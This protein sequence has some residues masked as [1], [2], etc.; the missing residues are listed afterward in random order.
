MAC[1]LETARLPSKWRRYRC[2]DSK[3][4]NR[5]YTYRIINQYTQLLFAMGRWWW[6]SCQDTLPWNTQKVSDTSQVCETWLDS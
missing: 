2:G 1:A 6:R 4:H 5:L 3:G